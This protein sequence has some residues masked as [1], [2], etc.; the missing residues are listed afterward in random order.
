MDEFN[1]WIQKAEHDFNT[2][3][4][5]F[6]QGIYD[7]SAFF[8]QQSIEKALKALY[9]KT[10][11]KLLKTH[12]LYYLGKKLSLPV[13]LLEICE[14]IGSFY[15]E[16]RYPD[17]YSEFDNKKVEESIQKTEKVLTWIRGKI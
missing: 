7:A 9:I 6:E 13:K 17:S 2:A 16:T 4:V 10:F 14:E 12:D 1:E 5:N 15:V 3:K 8:C 11:K